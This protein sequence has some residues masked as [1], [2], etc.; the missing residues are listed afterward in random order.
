MVKGKFA[1]E[2]HEPGYCPFCDHE[3]D[4]DEPFDIEKYSYDTVQVT[5]RCPNCGEKYYEDFSYEKTWW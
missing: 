4:F 3:N 1:A 2:T 5:Y